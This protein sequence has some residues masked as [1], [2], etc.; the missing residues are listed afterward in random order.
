MERVRQG[1]T[2]IREINAALKETF[3]RL[4]RTLREVV[5]VDRAEDV[6]QEAL[7]RIQNVPA[8]AIRHPRAY[9]L[10]IANN[11][12]RD[13]YRRQ[14]A[15]GG[16]HAVALDDLYDSDALSIPADQE[17]ALLLKQIILSMPELY[18]S[19]FLLNRFGGLSY[20]EIAARL[21]ISVKT[22]EWRMSRALQHCAAQLRA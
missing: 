16:G 7:L 21:D 1:K 11:V 10:R 13:Q 17:E 4:R 5:G 22:V 18:R 14:A 15:R 20:Q 6:A 2:Q 19:V 9:L 3:E 12:A 8:G